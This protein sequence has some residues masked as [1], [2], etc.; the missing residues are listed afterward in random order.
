MLQF[1]IQESTNNSESY[2]W[3]G[4]LPRKPYLNEK[5]YG[6]SFG[7]LPYR[8]YVCVVCV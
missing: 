3:N 6:N 8:L 7:I 1:S 5:I 2:E 4:S